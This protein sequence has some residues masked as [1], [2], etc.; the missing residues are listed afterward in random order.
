VLAASGERSV[1]LVAHDTDGLEGF[2]EIM[3]IEEGR[4]VGPPAP[5]QGGAD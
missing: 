1:L 4:I 5:E 3:V 2:G